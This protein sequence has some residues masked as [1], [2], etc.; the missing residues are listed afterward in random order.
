MIC[1]ENVHTQT[2]GLYTGL[3]FRCQYCLFEG[4]I[5]SLEPAFKST[6]SKRCIQKQDFKRRWKQGPPK[7]VQIGEYSPAS[8]PSSRPTPT[9]AHTTF[10]LFKPTRISTNCWCSTSCKHMKDSA[11]CAV[12]K[13][14]SLI[15]R[16]LRTLHRS[17][18]LKGEL[19]A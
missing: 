17:S 3:Q 2:S 8:S 6:R 13:E 4:V 16:D 19:V 9:K 14:S 5:S 7:Y 18:P 15:R 11:Q 12:L 10:L 1:S